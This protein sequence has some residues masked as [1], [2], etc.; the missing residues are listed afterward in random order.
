MVLS[1][2]ILESMY[3]LTELGTWLIDRCVCRVLLYVYSIVQRSQLFQREDYVFKSLV[4]SFETDKY[5]YWELVMF[6]RRFCIAS[7]NV[8]TQNDVN[9]HNLLFGA[10]L[11]Y[12][13]VQMKCN[14]FRIQQVNTLEAYAVCLFCLLFVL[15]IVRNIQPDDMNK[16]CLNV[17][18]ITPLVVYLSTIVHMVVMAFRI[19]QP[20]YTR[21]RSK[22]YN[23][24]LILCLIVQI[25]VLVWP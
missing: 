20:N 15:Y 17:L 11:M 8:V 5:W 9:A 2:S 6:S 18:I 3:V 12:L 22:L 13:V 4:I 24:L 1:I 14:P 19:K 21:D 25:A 10:M 23:P 16:M 7:I